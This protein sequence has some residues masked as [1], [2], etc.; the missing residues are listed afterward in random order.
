MPDDLIDQ[1]TNEYRAWFAAIGVEGTGPLD[2]MLAEDW[3]YTNYDG[4]VR[5]KSEYLEWVAGVTE[6]A[7]FV[8]PYDVQT[9]VRGDIVLVL[10]GYRVLHASD[11]E[12]LELRFSGVWAWS[13]ARW[14]CLLHHNSEVTG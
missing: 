10:G 13:G 2:S 6:S 11:N 1:L 7:T 8:G 4:L 9:H 3:M 12:I 5:G 14:Q